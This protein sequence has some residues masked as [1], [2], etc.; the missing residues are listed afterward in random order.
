[1]MVR[2]APGSATGSDPLG[3]DEPRSDPAVALLERIAADA[4]DEG[5]AAATRNGSHGPPTDGA[6]RWFLSAFG[7]ALIALVL[8]LAVA[9][10]RATQPETNQRKSELGAAV[11]EA[12]V[13]IDRVEEQVTSVGTDVELL[14]SSALD[15]VSAGQAVTEEVAALGE[16]AGTRA[17]TGPGLRV[18]ID[19]GP[20]DDDALA[21]GQPD[22]GRILD[23]DLQ[24]IVNGLWQAGAEAIDING[25]RLTSLTAIRGAGDAVLVNYRPLVRPYVVT[26][27]G[28]PNTL[29][30][31]FAS[32]QA[33]TELD[34]LQQTYGIRYEVSVLSEITVPGQPG[35]GLR[36]AEVAQP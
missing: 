16:S 26:A 8:A 23:R 32:G 11:S 18:T 31:G 20:V 28:D 2:P 17:V 24:I 7:L 33:G 22:L 6:R 14:R 30:P 9:Q 25:Q 19:D 1:M 29:P 15:S 36:Y 5:Y 27:I 35:V 4:L 12:G 34:V 10:L 21:N 3:H 13:R